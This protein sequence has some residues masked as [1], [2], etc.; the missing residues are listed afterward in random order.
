MAI[1]PISPGDTTARDK[2]NAAIVEANKVASKADAADLA[3]EAA[4][5]ASADATETAARVAG[6]AAEAAA[7][8]A[9]DAA[10]R[11]A[12]QAAL[13][14]EA[15]TRSRL[16][17]E[18]T[19][20]R[21]AAQAAADQRIDEALA[22]ASSR[23][24]GL[25]AHSRPGDSPDVFTRSL[26]AGSPA[27][28]P[29]LPVAVQAVS[30]GGLVARLYG[31]DIIASRR[32]VALERGRQY[33]L[34][35]ALRR[36]SNAEDPSNDAVEVGVAWFNAQMQPLSGTGSRTIV[37]SITD[38]MSHSGR[39]MVEATLANYAGDGVDH[40]APYG[41]I[42]GRAYVRTFGGAQATDVEVIA[43]TDIT[44]AILFAP[45]VADIEDRLGAQESLDAGARLEAL[46][47]A[48]DAPRRLGFRTRS[49][50]AAATIPV[51]VDI[52]EVLGATI[53]GT[54]AARYRRSA[55]S[56]AA[57]NRIQ[58][59]DG[60]WWEIA[61]LDV[62][63]PMLAV[64]MSGVAN[65]VPSLT[66]AHAALPIDRRLTL[67]PGL[68][69]LDE[70]V[71]LYGRVIDASG[72]DFVGGGKPTGALLHR[73]IDTG[74]W[75]IG[76]N[77]GDV[78]QGLQ[79]GGGNPIDGRHGIINRLE[80]H[81]TWQGLF[82]SRDLASMEFAVHTTAATGEVTSTI[83]TGNLVWTG[84][85]RAPNTAWIGRKLW[86]HYGVYRVSA[87]GGLD[88]HRDHRRGR[89]C[90]LFG[91]HDRSL[92]RPLHLR[93]RRLQCRGDHRDARQGRP[94]CHLHRSA[95]F[96]V[97]ACRGHANGRVMLGHVRTRAFQ[98][99]W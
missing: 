29:P 81:A 31:A 87:V 16:L 42:Y 98:S 50:A 73:T 17:A 21:E 36:A 67:G 83:G 80:G 47:S 62:T 75:A 39:R 55:A 35:V 7:R 49:A 37:R 92:F 1:S 20:A 32:A 71:S 84:R 9:G 46:E 40:L 74:L 54:G 33:R 90:Q 63:L 43:L 45:D 2:M 57:P 44:D 78:Y 8:A 70:D 65:A 68:I 18:E 66:S 12:R 96:P 27:D 61:D 93:R 89:A 15:G 60:A 94:L 48:V 99:A 4:A 14:A 11:Q 6:D 86:W 77:R 52:L 13:A 82:P 24:D 5:R 3:S 38:L 85:G 79:V 97:Q 25:A 41:A 51:D 26:S 91:C 28:L 34:R 22:V 69:R 58:T 59:A 76:G 64:D 19:K 30:S 95:R 23:V 53:P 88:H 10:E 72:A 56:T